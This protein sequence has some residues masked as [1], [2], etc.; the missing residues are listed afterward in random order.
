MKREENVKEIRIRGKFQRGGLR[1][2]GS[3]DFP[4]D[5][6]KSWAGVRKRIAMAG[7]QDRHHSQSWSLRAHAQPQS[8][9]PRSESSLKS[10]NSVGS[11]NFNL[12]QARKGQAQVL[13]RPRSRPPPIRLKIARS[14]AA[15]RISL[16]RFPPNSRSRPRPPS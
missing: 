14:V 10:N 16:P 5:E 9:H 4:L 11:L 12:K 8:L 6:R 2:K 15:G 1:R 13:G 7:C 3:G